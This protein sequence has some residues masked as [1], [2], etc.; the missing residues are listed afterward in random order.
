MA[1]K[2]DLVSRLVSSQRRATVIVHL[3][4]RDCD[5]L[6]RARFAA[7]SLGM[8]EMDGGGAG[9]GVV[10]HSELVPTLE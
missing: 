5:V 3:L 2:K 8:D 4:L 10:A 1:Q 7:E 9:N 6:E